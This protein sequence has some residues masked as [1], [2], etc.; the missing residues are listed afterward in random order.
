MGNPEH[1]KIL[2][3]GE[4][5]ISKWRKKHPEDGLDLSGE[6]LQGLDLNGLDLAYAN[7]SSTNLEGA[8]LRKTNLKGANLI[9][10]SG[11]LSQ[12]LFFDI[13]S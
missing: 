1:L 6:N 9:E 7:L 11:S 4:E 8:N 5:S 12:H 3:D 13:P 10:G 2:E